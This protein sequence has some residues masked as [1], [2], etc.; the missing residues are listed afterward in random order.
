MDSWTI[1]GNLYAGDISV[2]DIY[3]VVVFK[4]TVVKV[5]LTGEQLQAAVKEL[6]DGSSSPAL[7][8]SVLGAGG[9]LMVQGKEI[10]PLRV[11]TVATTDYDASSLKAMRGA[12]SESA[13]I[14]LADLILQGM[15][16]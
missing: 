8:G 9:K 12:K 6:T 11:Y 5:G 14:N 1:D 2:F 3:S 4:N 16:N 13:G 15:K 10:D 7:S